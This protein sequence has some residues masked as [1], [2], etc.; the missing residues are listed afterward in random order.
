M[1]S[2]RKNIINA[3]EPEQVSHCS[4][5]NNDGMKKSDKKEVYKRYKNPMIDDKTTTQVI[6]KERLNPTK[7]KEDVFFEVRMFFEVS[8]HGQKDFIYIQF[9]ADGFFLGKLGEDVL[10]L[11]YLRHFCMVGLFVD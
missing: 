10:I 6:V 5:D 8:N 2:C 1:T 11:T 9:G 4:S 7:R 3:S